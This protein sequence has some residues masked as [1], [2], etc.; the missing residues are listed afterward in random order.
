VVVSFFDPIAGIPPAI[1]NPIPPTDARVFIG[2]NTV[3]TKSWAMFTSPADISRAQN[4]PIV[5]EQ[6]T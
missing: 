1:P 6:K 2:P 4:Q 5:Q 3:Q